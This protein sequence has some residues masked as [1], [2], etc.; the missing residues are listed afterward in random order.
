M[1]WLRADRADAKGYAKKNK[2]RVRNEKS[3]NSNI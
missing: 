2:W 1:R 3:A